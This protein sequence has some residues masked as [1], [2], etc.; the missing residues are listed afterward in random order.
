MAI[1]SRQWIE[2]NLFHE[3]V[4]AMLAAVLA[5]ICQPKNLYFFGKVVEFAFYSATQ[6]QYTQIEYPIYT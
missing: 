2:L 4:A 5:V 1:Y 3:F 6:F